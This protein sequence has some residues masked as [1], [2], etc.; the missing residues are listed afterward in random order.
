M[1]TKSFLWLI[2]FAALS[3]QCSK[4]SVF[5]EDNPGSNSSTIETEA[6]FYVEGFSNV[7]NAR[8]VVN[9]LDAT[10]DPEFQYVASFMDGSSEGNVGGSKISEVFLFDDGRVF[11]KIPYITH[12]LMCVVD[13]WGIR[14][15][16]QW[17]LTYSITREAGKPEEIAIS[18]TG[19]GS[20][21]YELYWDE[22]D[23]YTTSEIL[24][25]FK[26]TQI[27]GTNDFAGS[28]TL[29]E[30]SA[31]AKFNLSVTGILILE[32]D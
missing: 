11:I 31:D 21:I 32:R 4:E 10:V 18:G 9:S 15:I 1:K 5:P 3:Y 6:Y 23:A 14:Y 29:D 22:T 12:S 8:L 27:E 25:E 20:H 7:S 2:L 24:F 17:D 30:K 26:G 19:R 16:N 28:F 13:G